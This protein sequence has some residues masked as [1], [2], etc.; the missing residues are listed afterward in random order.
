MSLYSGI[1]PHVMKFP[2]NTDEMISESEKSLLEKNIVKKRD[3]IVIIA[4]SPF[5]SGG[6]SN[7]MKLHKIGVME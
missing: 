5:E 1:A 3:S 2:D 4:S 7:I 6:K